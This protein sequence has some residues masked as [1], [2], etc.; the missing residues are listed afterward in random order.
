MTYFSAMFVHK[1]TYNSHRMPN[2]KAIMSW[3]LYNYINNRI[4]GKSLDT[5]D[6]RG[7]YVFSEKDF[8]YATLSDII[9]KEPMLI[10]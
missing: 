5:D 9:E 2:N 1:A 10:L 6:D 4:Y 3:D 8:P 7:Y